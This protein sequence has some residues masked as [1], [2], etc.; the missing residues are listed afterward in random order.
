M[1]LCV[2]SRRNRL[3]TAKKLREYC[4]ESGGNML[5][6]LGLLCTA[7]IAIT[8][9]GPARAGDKVLIAPQPGWATPAPPLDLASL[10]HRDN[11]LPLF[12]EQ[13]KLDGDTT[14]AFFDTASIISSPEALAKRG[15]ISINWQPDHG[16]L[17]FHRI[18]ILRAGQVIDALKNGADI[19]VLRR[20]AGLERLIVNG[21]LTAVKHIEGLQVGDVLRTSFS[22]TTRDAVLGGN[23]QDAMLLLP[24]PAQIGFGRARLVWPSERAISWR[25]MMPGVTATAKPL[26]AKST[27]LVIPLPVAKLPDLPKN[28]PS[29]YQAMPMLQFSSFADWGAVAKVMAPLYAVKGAIAPGSDLARRVDAIAAHSPDPVRRMAEALQM[30]QNE[31]RYQLVALGAG[32]YVPQPPAETWEKRFGD[33]K[34]KTA[35]LLAILDRLGIEAEPVLANAQ[36]GDA[37]PQMLPSVMAFDHVFVRARLESTDYWLDGTMLG[38]RLAD[39]HDIPRY[40]YVLPLFKSSALLD[41]PRRAHQRPDIDVDLTYD[42]SGGPHLPAPFHLVLHYAGAYA[43]A[44]KVEQGPEYDDKLTTVAEKAAKSWVGSDT[45]GK[46]AAH[47]DA[48]QATWTLTIDGVGYPDWQYRDGRYGLDFGPSLKVVFDAPR[49][50]AAWRTIPGLI[51]QPWTAHTHAVLNLPGGGRDVTVSG[52]DKSSLSSPAVDWERSASLAGSQ[53]VEDITSRESGAE[54]PPE[55]ISATG[56]SIA[57]SMAKTA[58]LALPLAYPQRWDDVARMRTAPALARVRALYDQRVAAKPED[59]VRLTDRAWLKERLFDWPGAEADYSKAI[60]TDASAERYLSRSRLRASRGDHAGALADAKAAYDLEQG[61]NDA[62]NQLANE[63]VEAKRIDDALELLPS[64]PDVATDQGLSDF[65]ARIEVL[66]GGNRHD[67]AIGLLDAALEKRSS[68]PELRNA[69]C[70]Y[71]G[72]RNSSLDVALADCNRAIELASNPAIY[73]DSR[74]LVNFRAGRLQQARSDYDA[75]LAA[76]PEQASSLFMSG[77]V[78]ARLGDEAAGEARERAART[79]FPDIDRFYLRYGIKP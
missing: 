25:T 24:A 78:L 17:I 62:R 64:D 32:N 7:A 76:S 45:I 28:M 66:E 43:E 9:A 3:A 22:V 44:S 53:F 34:A 11:I 13:V 67:E 73:L 52:T 23:I 40:G 46:P 30:V 42:M 65:L 38:S 33:C 56:K 63:L 19:T 51:D 31:V 1:L 39:I 72:L 50:R 18:E 58:H 10:P 12:D 29:R 69:R 77:M 47:Y 70:W 61:N 15:T 68:S 14:T 41:L 79:V 60:V 5:V 2:A 26:D 21:Q 54:I 16:D 57:D 20:E 6:R 48:E 27:E 59:A 4:L 8:L 37:V 35:L 75:A 36:R 74:A 55:K 71:H 49:D